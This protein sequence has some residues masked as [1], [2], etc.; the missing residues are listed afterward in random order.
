[1]KGLKELVVVR[2]PHPYETWPA[3]EQG[4]VQQRIVAFSRAV[5]LGHATVP[6][7]RPWSNLKELVATTED[8]WEPTSHPSA[9]SARRP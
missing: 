9:V 1:M 4:R 8:V 5:V 2:A 3:V 6:G 7:G